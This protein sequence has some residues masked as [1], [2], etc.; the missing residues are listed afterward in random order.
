MLFI[1]TI[2]LFQSLFSWS[3]LSKDLQDLRPWFIEKFQSLFSWSYL[4][5]TGAK[6]QIGNQEVV[7][8]LIFLELP[9]KVKYA[10]LLYLVS[11]SFNPYFP[12]VTFQSHYFIGKLAEIPLV[13]ILI[14]LELP[15]KVLLTSDRPARCC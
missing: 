2:T 13:S 5:K 3:Y 8:I 15:F 10:L 1:S 14:F 12:G 7:S 6:K 4:S 9:F 11:A